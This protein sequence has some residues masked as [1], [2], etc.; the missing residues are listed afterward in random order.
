MDDAFLVGGLQGFGNLLAML[1]C[2]SLRQHSASGSPV[3]D[4]SCR[5]CTVAEAALP[6]S[7]ARGIR[8]AP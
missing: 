4:G 6:V 1:L 3:T 7:D 2:W 8:C 5:A